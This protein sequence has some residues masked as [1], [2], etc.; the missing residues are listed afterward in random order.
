VSFTG[1]NGKTYKSKAYPAATDSKD[2]VITLAD[3]DVGI[4]V[5]NAL[6]L[7]AL[8][9][10]PADNF[11]LAADIDLAEGGTV[12]VGPTNYSGKFSG[13]GYTIKNLKF[14]SASGYV[15]LFTSL[16]NGALI[17]DFTV[18]AS[19]VGTLDISDFYFGAV[20]GSITSTG[21]TIRKVTVK[22]TFSFGNFAN[23]WAHIGGLIGGMET[24]SGI[25][26]EKCV[27]ELNMS[28]TSTATG[29]H[30]SNLSFGGL[31][32]LARGTVDITD[33]YSTG[34][35]D[36]QN[37]QTAQFDA[38]GLVGTRANTCALTIAI[39]YASGDIILRGSGTYSIR[40]YAGGLVGGDAET[41]VSLAISNSAALG[42][43]VLNIQTG[44]NGYY[45][46]VYGKADGGTF[47]NNYALSDMVT[48]AVDAA[49]PGAVVEGSLTTA[50]GLGKTAAQFMQEATW[51]D[52]GFDSAVWDFSTIQA[53]G[54]PV[55]R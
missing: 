13:N 33:S 5:E 4:S 2:T 22:G 35:I 26:I 14:S 51:T 31:I 40:R 18:E 42:K 39:S 21:I 15:G 55:L 9:F 45:G 30:Y 25:T 32:G 46:R 17:E 8:T 19:T 48:G 12:W 3:A 11:S 7:Q 20:S 1:S 53:Q 29:T 50:A 24:G 44:A 47:V 52:L 10:N 6:D 54:R 43:K 23:N 34:N 37:L 41:P 16:G 28:A 38:G 36:M 27:S 49:Y